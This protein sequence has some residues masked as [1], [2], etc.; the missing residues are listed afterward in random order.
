MSD[1]GWRVMPEDEKIKLA[2]EA[3]VIGQVLAR[4][5]S[6]TVNVIEG[7]RSVCVKILIPKLKFVC[8]GG[9]GIQSAMNQGKQPAVKIRPEV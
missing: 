9:E 3:K 6:M 5:R 2:Q 8:V 4:I 7:R 1:T